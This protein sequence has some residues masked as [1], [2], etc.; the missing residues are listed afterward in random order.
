MNDAPRRI[1]VYTAIFGKK[2][3]LHDPKVVPPNC[4]FICFTDQP[5]CSRVWRVQNVAPPVPGDPTRSA[6]KYKILAHEFLP[7]YDTSVWVDGNVLVRGD[8]NELVA[9]YLREANMAVWDHA[10]SRD[11][12]LRSVAEGKAL[13][14]Q[15]AKD[16]KPQDDPT[17]ISRQYEAYE[18]E[19]F[20]DD[21]GLLWSLVLLRRHNAPDVREAMRAW[22]NEVERWSKRD[23]MSFN[24]VA[25]KHR[26]KFAYMTG[27]PATNAY[28]KRLNHYLPWN[29]KLNSYRIGVVKRLRSFIGFSVFVFS[30]TYYSL[31][32]I[33]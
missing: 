31:L 32:T 17:V 7:E 10:Q 3:D 4:D 26:L 15:M 19:G 9:K 23:Q 5:L 12:P 24:Y 28:F 2:D 20:P 25:W 27:D 13:L 1:A 18:K 33:Y 16:G 22:W 8:V 21:G 6:R 14:V 11:F 30:A 29:R